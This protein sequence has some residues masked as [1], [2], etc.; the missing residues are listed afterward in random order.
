VL[1]CAFTSEEVKRAIA[2]QSTSKAIR[3]SGYAGAKRDVADVAP[4]ASV[5]SSPTSTGPS[6]GEPAEGTVQK[7]A[8]IHEYNDSCDAER[9]N[10]I[11]AAVCAFLVASVFFVD[12][13]MTLNVAYATKYLP[14][15]E[16]FRRR[17]APELFQDTVA[18]VNLMWRNMY[19][20]PWAWT[21][22]RPTPA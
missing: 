7:R 21:R 22:P 5:A 17:L 14:K 4:A 16:V 20:A 15:T 3:E 11:N 10:H 18:R 19:N 1:N 2:S 13:L 8:R 12:A 9:T 6:Q